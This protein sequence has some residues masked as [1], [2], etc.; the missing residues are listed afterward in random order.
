MESDEKTSSRPQPGKR[1]LIYLRTN[2]SSERELAWQEEACL[3]FLDQHHYTLIAIIKEDRI[4][5][6]ADIEGRSGTSSIS[7][8]RDVNG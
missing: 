7:D 6:N 8:M 5:E 3:K 1:A 4:S 2:D